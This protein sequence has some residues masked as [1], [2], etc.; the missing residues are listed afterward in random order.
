MTKAFVKDLEDKTSIRGIK[1][2][3]RRTCIANQTKIQGL[4]VI[5]MLISAV[6][7]YFRPSAEI[8]NSC[9]AFKGYILVYAIFN[10][11]P[12]IIFRLIE[13]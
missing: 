9:I 10:I 5:L 6:I 8:G 4:F 2:N 13:N 3:R 1:L 7:G 12:L 11:V